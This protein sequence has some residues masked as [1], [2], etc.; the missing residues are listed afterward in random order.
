MPGMMNSMVHKKMNRSMRICTHRNRQNW[1]KQANRVSKLPGSSPREARRVYSRQPQVTSV[2]KMFMAST[3]R[4][5]A[6]PPDR[7]LFW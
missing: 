7:L 4:L 1:R 6:N 5:R 3:A 2:R